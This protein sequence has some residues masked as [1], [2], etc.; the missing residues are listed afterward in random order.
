MSIGVEA[1]WA[2]VLDDLEPC[3]I[4]T[5]QQLVGNTSRGP[6]IS[7]LQGFRTEPLNAYYGNH[8]V[9]HDAFHCGV[10]LE[11]FEAGHVIRGL[12][13]D[14]SE[15]ASQ[16]HVLTNPKAYRRSSWKSNLGA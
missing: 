1:P 16:A 14:F 13:A 2:A 15:K 11:I 7:Q 10:G 3:L 6:F 9:G 8:L 4:T 5:I 12:L